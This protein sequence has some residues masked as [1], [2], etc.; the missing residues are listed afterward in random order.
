MP[1]AIAAAPWG[2]AGSTAPAALPAATTAGSSIPKGNA[3]KSRRSER[4]RRSRNAR[5]WIRTPPKS[6]STG[7]GCF[8]GT[9]RR[10][11]ARRS[12]QASSRNTTTRKTGAWF[13][14][15]LRARSTGG[16]ATRTRWTARTRLSC[17]PASGGAAPRKCRSSRWCRTTSW[18]TTPPAS[19]CP[20]SA[21]RSVL[22]SPSWC[23]KNAAR[24]WP[25][26]TTTWRAFRTASTSPARATSAK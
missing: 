6:I 13:R 5:G 16:A 21:A 10:R 18:A 26:P 3:W 23:L 17:M 19:G 14:W 24:P 12:R 1:A 2:W 4:K 8:L 7:C 9:S 25:P 20:P 15:S 22:T 11:T